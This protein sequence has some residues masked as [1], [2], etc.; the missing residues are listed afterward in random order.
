[1]T[2]HVIFCTHVEYDDDRRVEGI[3]VPNPK[4]HVEKQGHKTYKNLQN[5]TIVPT[6]IFAHSQI[7]VIFLGYVT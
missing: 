6:N 2:N 1:M 7:N 3:F 5:G 4:L